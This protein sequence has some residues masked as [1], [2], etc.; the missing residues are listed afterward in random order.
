LIRKDVIGIYLE[1]DALHYACARWEFKGWVPRRVN[2]AGKSSGII[3]GQGLSRLKIFLDSI[4][5]PKITRFYLG[6]PREMF[7]VRDMELPFM[8]VEDALEAAKNS[9]QVLCH[10]PVQEI[11]YDIRICTTEKGINVLVVYALKKI[12]D[13][14]LSCFRDMGL[15]N[16]LKAVFPISFGIGAWLNMDGYPL[17]FGVKLKHENNDEL[18]VFGKNG[19]IASV[20]WPCFNGEDDTAISGIILKFP[21]INNKIFCPNNNTNNSNGSKYTNKDNKKTEEKASVFN[22]ISSN[23]MVAF[24]NVSENLGIA[25]MSG[26]LSSLQIVSVDE[27]PPKV[28]VFKPIWIIVPL[29]LILCMIAYFTT[30]YMEKAVIQKKQEVSIIKKDIR[31]L[32]NKLGPLEKKKAE[33]K[34]AAEFK[35]D[36]NDFVNTRRDIF[37][38]IN[39]IAENVPDETWFTRFVYGNKAFTL[40]GES[41][42]AL[43]TVDALRDANLFEQVKMAGSVSR[44]SSGKER[45]AMKITLRETEPE[46]DEKND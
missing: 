29:I 33:E 16:A 30:N 3:R 18:T 27:K 35:A 13:P 24:P 26:G 12:I 34:N 2:P 41:P 10:L 36:V 42:D 20:V 19:P 43:K 39:S 1:K 44:S 28:K 15:Q 46:L 21:E 5:A 37:S 4:P 11:Y 6:L 8:P 17:P 9:L 38:L 23:K 22:L 32:K 7:F 40:N 31:N 45:F 14:Y 25:A